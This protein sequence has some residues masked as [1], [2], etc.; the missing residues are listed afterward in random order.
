MNILASP[1]QIHHLNAIDNLFIMNPLMASSLLTGGPTFEDNFFCC[2]G[3]NKEILCGSV[4]LHQLVKYLTHSWGWQ[5]YQPIWNKLDDGVPINHFFYFSFKSCGQENV[6]SIAPGQLHLTGQSVVC[7]CASSV[8]VL[9]KGGV[10][11]GF[12]AEL[13]LLSTIVDI[14]WPSKWLTNDMFDATT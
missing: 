6:Y 9:K 7:T 3:S 13:I 8:C 1:V 5:R 14:S 10:C 2:H 11:V 12:V 4:V